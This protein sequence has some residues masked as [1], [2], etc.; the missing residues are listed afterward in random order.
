[1]LVVKTVI[2]LKFQ[3]SWTPYILL[4][5]HLG[6]RCYHPHF[7]DAEVD[8][9]RLEWLLWVI[10]P[11]RTKA[12][13]KHSRLG[14]ESSRS[15]QSTLRLDCPRH[16]YGLALT[17]LQ[18]PLHCTQLWCSPVLDDK[19]VSVLTNLL[20]SRGHTRVQW[21]IVQWKV[22]GASRGDDVF[23]STMYYR[24]HSLNNGNL[25]SLSWEGW[26]VQVQGAG[27]VYFM[28]RP[29]LLAWR[30]QQSHCVLTWPVLCVCEQREKGS[31]LSG[32]SS[33]KDTNPTRLGIH[34]MTSGN[35]NYSHKGVGTWTDELWTDTSIP[36][37]SIPEG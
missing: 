6:S 7:S 9:G 17:Y 2:Y 4:A 1:M 23:C 32:V 21:M 10:E 33:C 35:L 12:G 3:F 19:G 37:H 31:E 11:V 20:S 8:S 36:F 16:P 29:L 34:F 15:C 22:W 5:P 18:P 28:L 27:K 25:F 30:Q 13:L 26:E 24:S 14:F